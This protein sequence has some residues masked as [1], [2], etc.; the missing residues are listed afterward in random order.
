MKHLLKAD[1]KKTLKSKIPLVLIIIA[2]ALPLLSASFNA[3]IFHLIEK[4]LEP[5]AFDG[6]INNA[7]LYANSFSPINNLGILLLIL[8]IILASHDFS[9]ATI[10]NKI[11]AGHNK[12]KIYLSSL[13]V[14]LTIMLV[15]MFLYSTL[16]YLFN[17]LF[18]GFN[19]GEFVLVLKSAAIGYSGL[20]TLYS[21]IT[22]L[23]YKY[24]KISG[25][26][27]L[28][29]GIFFGLIALNSL[30]NLIPKNLIDFSFFQHIF[31]I[32]RLSTAFELN[33]E[34]WWLALIV[35]I[36]ETTLLIFLGLMIAN[37]T[38]YN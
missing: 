38:D 20:I 14:N 15:V 26:I 30:L 28:T 11:I 34:F 7:Y 3:L 10:R 29:L 19:D 32:I 33:V 13:V 27:L 22:L 1:F 21:L 17:G 25:P 35:N 5:G 2:I 24:K 31:P 18:M 36:A 12:S 6:I 9:Q 16:T 4:D 23:M 37:K 8:V